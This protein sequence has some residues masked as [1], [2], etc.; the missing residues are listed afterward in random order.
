MT[1]TTT[2]YP[3][4]E[5]IMTERFADYQW[6]AIQATTRDDYNLTFFHLYKDGVSDDTLPPI[7]FQHGALM[8]A[9]DWLSWQSDAS[10]PF[11]HLVDDGYH[12]Y[13]GNNR[14]VEY[15]QSNA[16]IDFVTQ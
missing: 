12:V 8:S 1:T 11:F 16:N 10:S 15:S 13:L 3:K 7:F 14:G 5:A 4:F 6:E 2:D 9:D